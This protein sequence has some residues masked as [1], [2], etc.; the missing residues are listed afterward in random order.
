MKLRGLRRLVPA[1]GSHPSRGAW[2]EILCDSIGGVSK[3]RSHPSRGA[4]IE[5][6]LTPINAIS[7]LRRT[8]HGVRGLKL[9]MVIVL[10]AISTVAPLTGC[11]D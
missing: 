7:P 2:I 6:L 10:L 9:L 3:E 8:P 1:F 4:W 11:V 5:I